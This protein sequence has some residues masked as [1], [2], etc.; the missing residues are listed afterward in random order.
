MISKAFLINSDKILAINR[1]PT[2]FAIQGQWWS[3][4]STHRPQESQCLALFRF[5]MA[6]SGQMSP[7]ELSD[8]RERKSLSGPLGM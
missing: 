4:M 3:K 1:T 6:Q 7:G 8:I 5:K 2:Q